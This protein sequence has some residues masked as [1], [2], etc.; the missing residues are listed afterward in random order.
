MPAKGAKL[1]ITPSLAGSYYLKRAVIFANGEMKDK[2]IVRES[3]HPGDFIIAADGGHRHLKALGLRP[4]LVIGDLDSL[5][6]ND[7]RSLVHVGAAIQQY[8]REKDETDLELSLR[9]AVIRGFSRILIVAAL[10]GR[11]DQT[12]GNLSLLA[13]PFL[14][15]SDVTLED[16]K[17][18]I[19][20]LTTQRY[21]KGLKINGNVG[22]LVSLIAQNTKVNGIKTSGLK[23]P[24][25]NEDLQPYETR[26]ISNVLIGKKAQIKFKAGNL[27][28]IHTRKE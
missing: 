26:G 12:Q 19:W 25:N 17:D 4:D 18:Q 8:P 27:L 28:V 22:D 16:G 7:Y 3:I 13:A 1:R 2:D 14:R 6:K 11:L 21:P 23:Y 15:Q 10:G 9:E 20:L 5:P 24:L